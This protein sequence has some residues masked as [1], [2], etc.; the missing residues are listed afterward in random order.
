MVSEEESDE[1]FNCRPTG[2]KVGTCPSR[3]KAVCRRGIPSW[4][5]TER[6]MLRVKTGPSELQLVSVNPEADK[7]MVVS[8]NAGRRVGQPSS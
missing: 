1:Y 4:C 3:K 5:N 7:Y 2:S 8:Y 6:F